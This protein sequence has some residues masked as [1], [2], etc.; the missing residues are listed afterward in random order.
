MAGLLQERMK[1]GREKITV[2]RAREEQLLFSLTVW[3]FL[4][5]IPFL[6]FTVSSYKLQYTVTSGP[7]A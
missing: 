3:W 6:A 5:C 2:K 4:S 1:E 7:K